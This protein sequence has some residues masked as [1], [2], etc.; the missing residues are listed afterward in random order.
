MI[1]IAFHAFFGEKY[2]IKTVIILK[3]EKMHKDA[4]N[5]SIF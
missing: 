3:A 2:T 5:L 4:K 1:C